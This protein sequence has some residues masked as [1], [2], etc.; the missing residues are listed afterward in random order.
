MPQEGSN[1]EERIATEGNFDSNGGNFDGNMMEALDVN[2][3]E[4]GCQRREF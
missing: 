3:R 1:E 4:S 2:G